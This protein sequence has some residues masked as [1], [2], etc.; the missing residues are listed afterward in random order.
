MCGI[1]GAKTWQFGIS[2]TSGPRWNLIKVRSRLDY[3]IF[4]SLTFQHFK[5][6]F[7]LEYIYQIWHQWNLIKILFFLSKTV[8]KI[9]NKFEDMLF[10]ILP[11][12]LLKPRRFSNLLFKLKH[13]CLYLL[14]IPLISNI[15]N[16]FDL[17]E[18]FLL[19]E[20]LILW[21]YHKTKYFLYYID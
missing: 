11:L 6:Q 13:W 16:L 9:D 8:E 5:D 7:T 14:R 10:L 12:F 17:N 1:L 19:R 2:F 20:L 21:M 18:L 3:I 15:K 4:F